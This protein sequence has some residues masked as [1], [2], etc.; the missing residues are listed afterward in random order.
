MSTHYNAFISYKHEV[1]DTKIAELVQRE[2]EH[3]NIPA[4]IK[5]ST[6]MKKIER[7]FRDKDEL[8]ITSDLSETILDALNHSDYLIVICSTKTRESI[9]VSREIDFFLRTHTKKQILTVLV[10]G[11]PDDVIPPILLQDEKTVYNSYGQQQKIVTALEPLSCDFRLPKRHALKQELPRLASALIGCSYDDLINRQRQYMLRRMALLFAAAMAL[12]LSFGIY[13]FHSRRQIEKSYTSA[14]K[15]QSRYLANESEN[16]LEKEQRIK[17]I[18][19][20]LAALP[21]SSEDTSRPIIPEAVRALTKAS[22][23]YVSMSYSSIDT[24]GS[25]G[26]SNTIKKFTLSPNGQ[27][28]AANDQHGNLMVWNLQTHNVVFSSRSSNMSVIHIIY[29][30]ENNNFLYNNDKEIVCYNLSSS[31]EVWRYDLGNEGLSHNDFMFGK[32]S[33]YIPTLSGTIIKLDMK[34]GT[35]IESY[36]MPTT[37]AGDKA[38]DKKDSKASSTDAEMTDFDKA[39][40]ELA[41]FTASITDAISSEDTNGGTTISNSQFT[42]SPDES[43]IAFSGSINYDEYVLGC[44]DLKTGKVVYSDSQPEI[45]TNICW[46]NNNHIATSDVYAFGNSSMSIGNL[47]ILR[48]DDKNVKCFNTSD[49][50]Q[51]WKNTV[52]S[53]VPTS[54][55]GFT[56]IDDFHSLVYYGGDAFTV[57]DTETGKE[58]YSGNVNEEIIYAYRNEGKDYPYFITEGGKIATPTY[59]D[60][61]L[62]VYITKYFA[63]NLSSACIENGSICVQQSGS[64][65]VISYNSS[66]YDTSWKQ[67]KNDTSVI[68]SIPTQ[69]YL[70]NNILAF[71]DSKGTELVITDMTSNAYN[72]Y[73]IKISDEEYSYFTLLGV[74]NNKLYITYFDKKQILMEI[75][76]NS[77]SITETDISE[78]SISDF[79]STTPGS[80]T[81]TYTYTSDGEERYAT[82]DLNTKKEVEY[83]SPDKIKYPE[84]WHGTTFIEKLEGTQLYAVSDNNYVLLCD[85]KGDIKSNI[86]LNGGLPLGVYYYKAD[87]QD[88]LLVLNEESRLLRYD[89][90]TGNFLGSSLLDTALVTE[91]VSIT[92]NNKTRFMYNEK[93]HNLYVYRN[94]S[95]SVVDPESWVEYYCVSDCLGYHKESKRFITLAAEDSE[96]ITVGYFDQY[97]LDELIEKA[98]NLINDSELSVEQ[99]SAYGIEYDDD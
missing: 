89:P 20:A 54:S 98:R 55:D 9:W 17:A 60:D 40:A 19:L 58:R 47:T 3:Y 14:L 72:S 66:L 61:K 29:F 56:V 41:E 59:K 34:N 33:I 83:L 37:F 73:K 22:Y 70:D 99:K 51:M 43:Q 90:T 75:D 87:K 84:G 67:F 81:I 62:S 45:F 53:N 42:L 18:Q 48:D 4:K 10:D 50:S 24:D 5:K 6:G 95:I 2:L 32:D 92:G 68:S 31:E 65:E 39:F 15:S 26:L 11:E 23:A 30:L 38:T 76:L 27:Y 13:M 91:T 44:Y 97:N 49:M 69:Y 79:T 71:I 12:S 25:Y 86:T 52:I 64:N 57:I 96:R 74:Y 28:L 63:D 46:L 21:S 1:K 77:R 35:L 85:A 80:S 94:Y 7:I 16:L 93:D 88:I 78:K 8:P 82:Y 36:Q